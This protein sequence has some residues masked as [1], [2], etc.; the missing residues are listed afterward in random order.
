MQWY[1]EARIID[2]INEM[3]YTTNSAGD[4]HSLVIDS[5]GENEIGLY[6]IVVSLNGSNATDET[7]LRFLGRYI[8]TY[9]HPRRMQHCS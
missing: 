1:H 3:I 6:A 2:T 4:I 8:E 7:I 9:R 5:I